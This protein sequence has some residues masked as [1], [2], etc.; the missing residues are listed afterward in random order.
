VNHGFHRAA[1]AE[2]L[3]Q[4]SFYESQQPG[5]GARFIADVEAALRRICEH[6][7]AYRIAREPDIRRA[8]TRRFPFII[9]FREGSGTIEILAVGHRR[10]RPG[11]W[12]GRL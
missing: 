1:A 9:V 5:L 12:S 7:A 3:E 2:Y 4:V 11:F 10:R 8:Y 6:P